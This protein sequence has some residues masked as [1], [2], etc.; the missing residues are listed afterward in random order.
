MGQNSFELEEALAC[1]GASRLMWAMRSCGSPG[2]GLGGVGG[3]IPLR[4]CEPIDK[5]LA[6]DG[7]KGLDGRGA[8]AACGGARPFPLPRTRPPPSLRPD[9]AAIE[10]PPEW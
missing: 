3:D 5:E 8:W 9:M 2:S 7:A 6:S 4:F 10:V 1:T